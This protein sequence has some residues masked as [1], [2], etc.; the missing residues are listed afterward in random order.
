MVEQTTMVKLGRKDKNNS[1]F[2]RDKIETAEKESWKRVVWMERRRG[3]FLVGGRRRER[4]NHGESWWWCQ[5][6][7]QDSR[8]TNHAFH[9]T[10]SSRH[11]HPTGGQR[12]QGRALGVWVIRLG[13]VPQVRLAGFSRLV[14]SG[15]VPNP[16]HRFVARLC[17]CTLRPGTFHRHLVWKHWL[18]HAL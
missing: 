2:Y 4:K 12:I 11:P 17:R 16:F 8:G 6:P 13:W 10:S 1:S 7:D 9:T 14:Q 15:I 3:V 18:Q 5:A